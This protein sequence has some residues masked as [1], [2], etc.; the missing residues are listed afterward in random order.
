M[1]CSCVLRRRWDDG[2]CALTYRTSLQHCWVSPMARCAAIETSDE[3]AG[4]RRCDT[5]RCETRSIVSV[6][7]WRR[8][9]ASVH[10]STLRAR[11]TEVPRLVWPIAAEDLNVMC[12]SQCQVT[13]VT[14]AGTCTPLSSSRSHRET[15]GRLFR[16]V[17]YSP[18]AN[19]LWNPA[20]A[21]IPSQHP[22][23]LRVLFS[24]GK[25]K[26]FL[27][28]ACQVAVPAQPMAG[29]QMGNTLVSR[30]I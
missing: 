14:P 2:R 15:A 8:G 13:R 16:V 19:Y 28:R 10:G 21:T 26:P 22:G 3:I 7:R 29:R 24:A 9:G 18:P 27:A 30:R 23:I 5:R 20:S 11:P 6:W 4:E 1:S 25:P 12:I 17:L